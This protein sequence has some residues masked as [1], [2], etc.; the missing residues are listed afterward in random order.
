MTV[1]QQ[2]RNYM[3]KNVA[4]AHSFVHTHYSM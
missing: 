1:N 3:L 2:K 4:L